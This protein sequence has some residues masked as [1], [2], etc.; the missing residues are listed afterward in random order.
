[1]RQPILGA[2]VEHLRQVQLPCFASYKLDGERAT[3][4][5][6]EFFSRTLKTHPNRNLQKL[7]HS[8]DLPDGLDGELILGDPTEPGVFRRTHSVVSSLNKPVD[9]IRFFAFDNANMQL[10]FYQRYEHIASAERLPHVIRLDH[11]IIETYDELEAFYEVCIDLNYEG[12]VCRHP[13]GRY[14]NGRSTLNEQL[15]L[16]VK[17]VIDAVLPIIAI[18]EMQ[19]NVNPAT[20]DERGYTKRSSHQDGKTPA[21]VAGKVVVDWGDQE[22]RIGTGF[23][24]ED[25]RKLWQMRDYIVGRYLAKFEYL[26][27]GIK[28][29]P[30]HPSFV[31]ICE[32]NY[33]QPV[34]WEQIE[35]EWKKEHDISPLSSP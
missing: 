27:Y 28:D 35:A 18:E 3:W 30:R 10:P 11:Q 25:R 14:K 1:M 5:M 23:S 7:F 34:G 17:P 20:R 13:E 29:L 4:Q 33:K 26:P 21:G 32:P 6:L 8:L 24:S 19:H 16:K 22:L 2:K 31:A 15:L 12:M 9:G